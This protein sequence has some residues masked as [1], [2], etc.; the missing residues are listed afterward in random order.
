MGGGRGLVLVAVIPGI[1]FTYA[2]AED[3]L[4]SA[5]RGILQEAKE[6]E[7]YE[8][9]PFY[10]IWFGR[11]VIQVLNEKQWVSMVSVATS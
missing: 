5:D 4:K 7:A 8:A 2:G 6:N 1:L 10:P 11:L 9:P 3:Y